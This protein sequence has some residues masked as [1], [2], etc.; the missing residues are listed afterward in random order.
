[1]PTSENW[2]LVST[3]RQCATYAVRRVRVRAPPP[4]REAAHRERQAD[5]LPVCQERGGQ[6]N[7][8]ERR[9]RDS[10]LQSVRVGVERDDLR[11]DARDRLQDPV[12][13]SVDRIAQNPQ[14]QSAEEVHV[15]LVASGMRALHFT[16]DF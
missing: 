14:R 15:A 3:C 13:V 10:A 12:V 6:P 2:V 1:M 4:N 5:A 7:R 9:A 11:H 8:P 16:S